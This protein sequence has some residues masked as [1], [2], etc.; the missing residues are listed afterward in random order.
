[1]AV[2]SANISGHEPPTT[3][4]SAKQQ[5]GTSVAVYLDGGETPVG[6]PSTIID[7]SGPRPYLLREGAITA[8]RIGEVLGVDAELLRTRP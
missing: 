2:S 6:R 3:A 7:L 8:E 5:L 1:M 4:I